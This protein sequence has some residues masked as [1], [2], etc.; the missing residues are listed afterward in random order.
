[1]KERP[2]LWTDLST[3]AGSKTVRLNRIEV[4]PGKRSAPLHV[5]NEEEEI[6]YVLRGSGLSWQRGAVADVTYEVRPI[7]RRGVG[8]CSPR[9]ASPGR[10][11][12]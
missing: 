10:V 11:W 9:E 7:L 1:M 2:D 6:F 12:S 5:E 8:E 3:P 4:D